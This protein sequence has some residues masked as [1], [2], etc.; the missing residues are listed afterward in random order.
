MGDDIIGVISQGMATC[1]D[2]TGMMS[3]GGNDVTG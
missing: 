3:H 2:I 1:G